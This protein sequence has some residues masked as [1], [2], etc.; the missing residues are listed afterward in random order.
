M[1]LHEWE[2]EVDNEKRDTFLSDDDR[3]RG[4][5]KTHIGYGYELLLL[6]L[7]EIGAI[8]TYYQQ[9]RSRWPKSS[10]DVIGGRTDG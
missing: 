3:P 4:G 6:N 2:E 8:A 1:A 9:Q 10:G 7:I 5:P